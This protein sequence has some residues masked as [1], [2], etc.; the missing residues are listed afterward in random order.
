MAIKIRALQTGQLDHIH[1]L[2]ITQTVK[3]GRG[4]AAGFK[5]DFQR[6][7]GFVADSIRSKGLFAR[8]AL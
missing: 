3:P 2:L 7:P 1:D 5:S 6:A 4:L 8:F